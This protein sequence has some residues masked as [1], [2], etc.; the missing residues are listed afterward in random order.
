MENALQCLF[1]HPSSAEW[2]FK[3]HAKPPA[4]PFQYVCMSVTVSAVRS[5]YSRKARR[6]TVLESLGDATNCLGIQGVMLT[7]LGDL[8][9]SSTDWLEP[10]FEAVNRNSRHTH[11]WSFCKCVC[12]CF[13]FFIFF[14]A[15]CL[16]GRCIPLV[17]C[18]IAV[19]PSTF[20]H[21]LM[22]NN[23]LIGFV[24][25]VMVFREES[26]LQTPANRMIWKFLRGMQ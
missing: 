6:L 23:A 1:L 18:L 22:K 14:V 15:T 25:N 4:P 17:F 8:N 5:K 7:Y 12:G 16:T 24:R 26:I 19:C 2:V 10:T 3:C 13:Y 20:R 21:S 11:L 9:V